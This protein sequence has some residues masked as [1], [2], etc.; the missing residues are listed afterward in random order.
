MAIMVLYFNL[1]AFEIIN[2][3][4]FNYHSKLVDSVAC[5]LMDIFL[6]YAFKLLLHRNELNVPAE[7]RT[8]DNYDEL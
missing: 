3:D 5:I 4:F 7:L 2:V 8:Y 6:I 1:L